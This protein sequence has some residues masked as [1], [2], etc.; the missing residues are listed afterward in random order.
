[1]QILKTS[2]FSNGYIY[3]LIFIYQKYAIFMTAIGAPLFELCFRI[4]PPHDWQRL[5]KWPP[6]M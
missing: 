2:G 4:R 3:I 1:M 6:H 5:G